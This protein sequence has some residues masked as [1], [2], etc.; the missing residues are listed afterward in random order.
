MVNVSGMLVEYNM[1]KELL[2]ILTRLACAMTR[3]KASH[4]RHSSSL[5]RTALC[6][7]Q[8]SADL[9]IYCLLINIRRAL[10]KTLSQIE[11]AGSQVNYEILTVSEGP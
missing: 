6:I 4:I 5:A 11:L 10:L 3:Y 8:S 7:F 9:S 2:P 1:K